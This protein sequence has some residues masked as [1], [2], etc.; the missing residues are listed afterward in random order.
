MLEINRTILYFHYR[1]FRILDT[2]LF[3]KHFRDTLHTCY[4]HRNHNEYHRKHHQTHQDVHAVS[5]H[6]HQITGCHITIDNLFCT[7]PTDQ[8]NTS[9]NRSHHNWHN[10]CH[11]SLN[12]NEHIVNVTGCKF[13]L[14]LLVLFSYIRL[15]NS[16]IRNIF[17]YGFI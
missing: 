7:I 5:Q 4:G 6:R 11:N 15:Y 16:Y 12:S 10:G 17:L 3:C 8:K 13:E 1:I 2:W 14:I 9:V